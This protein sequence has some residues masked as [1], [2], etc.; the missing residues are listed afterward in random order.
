LPRPGKIDTVGHSWYER[1]LSAGA[2]V[3]LVP[4]VDTGSVG[5]HLRVELDMPPNDAYVQETELVGTTSGA[6]TGITQPTWWPVAA[7]IWSAKQKAG[8]H[9]DDQDQPDG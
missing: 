1:A 8:T 3:V 2:L 7:A 5:D 6:Y 9:A 4:A